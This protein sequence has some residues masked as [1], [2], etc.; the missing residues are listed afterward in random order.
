MIDR[1]FLPIS[2]VSLILYD[3][4]TTRLLEALWGRKL[5]RI[6]PREWKL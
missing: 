5:I 4:I 2:R 6:G 3:R 1:S